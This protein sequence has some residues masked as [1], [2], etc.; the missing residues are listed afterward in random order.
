MPNE[1]TNPY[2]AVLDELAQSRGLS[3]AEELAEKAAE[4]VPNHTP[5]GILEGTSR[6][7]G[8]ALDAVLD[9]TDEEKGRVGLAVMDYAEQRRRR[10]QAEM[11]RDTVFGEVLTELLEKR[12][13]P[14]TPFKV[15]KLAEDAGLNGWK[16][17]NRMASP[18]VDA[19]NLE[20]LA[21]ALELDDE[22]TVRLARAY[23]LEW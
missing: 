14:V 3:G 12:D 4:A 8:H 15:G 16:V 5:E 1:T 21:D 9:L 10:E 2:R 23:A 11:L 19:G 17:I 22:E 20:P 13:L 6:N 18:H 7:F